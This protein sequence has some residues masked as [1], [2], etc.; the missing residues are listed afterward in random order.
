[1]ARVLHLHLGEVAFGGA[2]HVHAP[3]G[4]EREVRRVGGAE[5]AEAQPVGVV[6][7]VATDGREEALGRGVGANDEGDLAEAGDKASGAVQNALETQFGGLVGVGGAA[8]VRQMVASGQHVTHGVVT[9][10]VGSAGLLLGA[11]GAFLS[12]QS[13]LNA[14]WEVKPDPKQGGIKRFITK[15]LLSFGML[16][17]LAFLLVA[18]LAI[19]A[20][21]SALGKTLGGAGVVMQIVNL[22]VSVAVLSVLFA[23]MFKFLPD[24][25]VRWRFTVGSSASGLSM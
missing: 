7:T 16:M 8:E 21:I 12:L 15:R 6:G 9:A 3:A 19:T 5:Q 24:A 18:S 10:I 20:A 22:A 4:V 1:M 11:T 23:A 17:G 2:V 25:V 14:V 13:A